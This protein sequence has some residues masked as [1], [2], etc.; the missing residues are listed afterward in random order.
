M[1]APSPPDRG[2]ASW[3]GADLP[4]DTSRTVVR[5]NRTLV[6]TLFAALASDPRRRATLPHR[7]CSSVRVTEG[8]AALARSR[9]A[10]TAARFLAVE[11]D[12]VSLGAS[13]PLQRLAALCD[14]PARP[15]VLAALLARTAAGAEADDA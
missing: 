1:P 12:E 3:H 13:A 10:F 5:A 9:T 14:P 7:M 4:L 6:D 11:D 2:T 8:R 15:D